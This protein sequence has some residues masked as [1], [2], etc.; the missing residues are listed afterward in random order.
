MA[1]QAVSTETSDYISV[2]ENYYWK[3]EKS[4]GAYIEFVFLGGVEAGERGCEYKPQEL[5]SNMLFNV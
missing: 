3:A 5:V 4:N 1:N 2:S